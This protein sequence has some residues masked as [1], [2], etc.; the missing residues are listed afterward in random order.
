M[1]LISYPLL[2]ILIQALH[3]SVGFG[4]PPE[5]QELSAWTLRP[6]Q[7]RTLN[8]ERLERFSVS[9]SGIRAAPLPDSPHTLLIKAVGAGSGELWI[10]T[11]AL[12]IRHLSVR[13]EASDLAEPAAPQP[14]QSACEALREVEVFWTGSQAVL[15]G[16]I[17]TE[18]ELLRVRALAEAHPT[19]VVDRTEI[20][21]EL[22]AVG[23]RRIEGW[24]SESTPRPALAL[25]EQGGQ[26]HVSGAAPTPSIRTSWEQKIRSLFAGARIELTSLAQPEQVLYFRVALIELKKRAFRSLGLQWPSQLAM[27]LRAQGLPKVDF[28]LQAL[29]REGAAKVLSQPELVVRVPGEAELFSGGEIPIEMRSMRGQHVEWKAYGLSLKLKAVELSGEDVRLEISSE[30]SDLDRA[31][32]SAKIPALQASRL[33]TQVDARIGLPLFLSGLF[34]RRSSQTTEGLPFLAGIPLLGRLFGTKATSEEQAEL[35]ALL[36]PLRAPPESAPATPTTPGSS[37]PEVPESFERLEREPMLPGLI[38]ERG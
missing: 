38:R 22:L 20:A 11:E 34:Q 10:W 2:F 18:A 8:V 3:P 1:R 19:A 16:R 33:K 14:L 37:T 31:N 15:S 9:G 24:L 25:T 4:Q 27:G 36:L 32:G 26:L 7:S 17:R 12:K 21:G 6:G 30:V 28:E 13:V 35:V 29:E 5:I 23:R